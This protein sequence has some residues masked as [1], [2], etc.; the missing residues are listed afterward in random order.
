MSVRDNRVASI[1]FER[2]NMIDYTEVNND[3]NL[4][5]GT[6]VKYKPDAQVF[7]LEPIEIKFEHLCKSLQRKVLPIKVKMV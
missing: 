4:P 5:N 6:F 3:K 2:G 1:C 7:N